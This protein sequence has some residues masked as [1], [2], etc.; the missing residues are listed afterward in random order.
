VRGLLEARAPSRVFGQLSSQA[1][2]RA[3][4]RPPVAAFTG[5]D[6]NPLKR[7]NQTNQPLAGHPV[8]VRS[9]KPDPS[10]QINL[11]AK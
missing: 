4:G 7:K 5:H 10:S 3:P 8:G 11:A 2:A 6:R 9:R 1:A